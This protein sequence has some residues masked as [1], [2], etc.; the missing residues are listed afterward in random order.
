MSD[1]MDL[2]DE[3]VAYLIKHG[4]ETE[5][6]DGERN[7]LNAVGGNPAWRAKPSEAWYI[8][9]VCVFPCRF[10]EFKNVVRTRSPRSLT[11]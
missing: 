4:R 8:G 3:V 5:G 6:R 10:V 1:K 7:F 11:A 2:R 9:R